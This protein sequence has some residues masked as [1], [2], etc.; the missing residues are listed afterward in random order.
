MI[1]EVLQF[2]IYVF[3]VHINGTDMMGLAIVTC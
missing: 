1:D 3:N 2:H